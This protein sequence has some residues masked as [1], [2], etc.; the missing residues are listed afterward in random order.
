MGSRDLRSA[1][2][3]GWPARWR[4]G[5]AQGKPLHKSALAVGCG[6][7]LELHL[8]VVEVQFSPLSH[9]DFALTRWVMLT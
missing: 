6:I 8:R 1:A 3:S 7:G 2:R 4:A 5:P 9:F